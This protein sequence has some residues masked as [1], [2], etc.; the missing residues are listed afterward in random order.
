VFG[1]DDGGETWLEVATGLP[2]INHLS[3]V[4]GA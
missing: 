1:S 3:I 2:P 4:P